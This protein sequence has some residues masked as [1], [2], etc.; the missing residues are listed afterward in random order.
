MIERSESA[1][2]LTMCVA[3]SVNMKQ[4]IVVEILGIV[5]VWFL[6]SIHSIFITDP[7]LMLLYGN[8]S[9]SRCDFC[10]CFNP[11]HIVQSYQL[12]CDLK[13]STIHPLIRLLITV[14]YNIYLFLYFS[15]VPVTHEEKSVLIHK[16][17]TAG[18]KK[19]SIMRKRQAENNSFL[20]NNSRENL[21]E[22]SNVKLIG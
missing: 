13:T 3:P 10:S 19:D 5:V 18:L 12:L 11:E 6:V 9:H 15:T 1:V 22:I 2:E 20:V 16:Q 17:I 8:Y 4:Y 14:I 7:M 21:L